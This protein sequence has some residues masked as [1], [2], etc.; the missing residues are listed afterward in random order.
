MSLLRTVDPNAD[1]RPTIREPIGVKDRNDSG[2]VKLQIMGEVTYP[3]LSAIADEANDLLPDV[4]IWN[5]LGGTTCADRPEAV[6]CRVEVL[7]LGDNGAYALTYVWPDAPTHYRLMQFNTFYDHP[8]PE[9][10]SA[11]E[12]GHVLGMGHHRLHGVDG[13]W[14]DELHFSDS[15]RNCLT[16]VYSSGAIA[17]RQRLTADRPEAAR[18]ATGPVVYTS[19][20]PMDLRRR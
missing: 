17:A 3:G 12:F 8:I 7:D 10:L 9:A 11:H 20:V 19:P 2:R 4:R 6:C 15:E 14:P 16:R 13:G 5:G 18:Q 1:D